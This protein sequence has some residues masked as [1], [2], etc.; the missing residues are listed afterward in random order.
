VKKYPVFVI[1]IVA[2]LLFSSH[3]QSQD[4]SDIKRRINVG[5]ILCNNVFPNVT[6][7]LKYGTPGWGFSFG[8]DWK[9]IGVYGTLVVSSH[10]VSGVSYVREG[11]TARYNVLDVTVKGYPLTSRNFRL[12]GL[13]GLCYLSFDVPDGLVDTKI[14]SGDAGFEGSG[15]ELGVGMDFYVTPR[16]SFGFGILY[17]SFNFHQMRLTTDQLNT[18]PPKLSGSGMGYNLDVKFSVWTGD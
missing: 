14:I 16:L 3:A 5:L 18:I 10:T 17:R 1:L 11:S 15:T 12:Y 4:S 8:T 6:S 7:S 13:L 9:R 2:Q